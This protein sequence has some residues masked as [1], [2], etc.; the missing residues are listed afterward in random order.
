MPFEYWGYNFD[1]AYIACSSLKTQQGVYVIW[2]ND[3]GSWTVL[4]VGE[5]ENVQD[6]TCNHE[7]F[8]CWQ[9]ICPGTIYF[10]AVYTPG[11]TQQQRRAIER[12]IR[13]LSHPPCGEG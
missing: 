10:S 1:G 4:D 5:S 7:R 2:C 3:K 6:R 9:R 13:N 12:H 8:T 11:E